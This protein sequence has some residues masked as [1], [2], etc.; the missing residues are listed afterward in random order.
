MYNLLQAGV[1]VSQA[2]ANE[3][4]G[5]NTQAFRLAAVSWLVDNNHLLSEFES[6]SFRKLITA[7]NP[8][9]DAVLWRSHHSVSRYVLRLY[10]H[11]KPRVVSELSQA[12]SKIHITF[13]GWTTKGG[14][15]GFLGVVAHYVDRRGKLVDLPIALPELVGSHSGQAMAK[16]IHKT[17]EEFGITSSTVGYFVLD[18]ASNNDSAVA[19]LADTIGFSHLQRRLRCGPHTLNLIGQQ[20]LWGSDS[21]AY[22]NDTSELAEE[23]QFMRQ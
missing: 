11:L 10:E 20:L 18:N 17:L 15:R 13:D 19:A 7:A 4:N 9:A 1:S 23:I 16:V 5:F 22:D 14:K 6:P 21:A 3:L 2:I 8:L 12:L